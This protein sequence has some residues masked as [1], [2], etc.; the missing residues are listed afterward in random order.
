M[1][2]TQEVKFISSLLTPPDEYYNRSPKR[3]HYLSDVDNPLVIPINKRVRFLITSQ[4]CDP[5][6]VG[7]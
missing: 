7:A 6:L 2:P 4:R 1:I 5:L 3:E